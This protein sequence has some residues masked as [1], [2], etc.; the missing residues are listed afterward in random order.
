[1]KEDYITTAIAVTDELS[2]RDG[3]KCDAK[4]SLE[5]YREENGIAVWRGA[6]EKYAIATE[7]FL[8]SL[9]DDDRT[10]LFDTITWDLEWLPALMERLRGKREDWW[11]ANAG[12]IAQASSEIMNERK[13]TGA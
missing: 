12:Q 9:S 5:K 13:T 11:N 6:I 3:D 1:M 8:D 2:Y 10:D 7:D 4:A